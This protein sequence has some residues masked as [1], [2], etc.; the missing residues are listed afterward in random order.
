MEGQV[1]F[2]IVQKPIKQKGMQDV[3]TYIGEKKKSLTYLGVCRTNELR[4][5]KNE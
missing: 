1:G 4:K 3:K 2:S 5:C